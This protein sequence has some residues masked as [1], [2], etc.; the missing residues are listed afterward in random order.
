MKPEFKKEYYFLSDI[1]KFQGIVQLGKCFSFKP[2]V[3]NCSLRIPLN[4]LIISYSLKVNTNK[5]ELGSTDGFILTSTNHVV[6]KICLLQDQ[7][8]SSILYTKSTLIATVAA[9][10]T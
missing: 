6:S 7:S 1:N 9:Q 8:D 3:L 10:I 2:S 4:Y 5:A